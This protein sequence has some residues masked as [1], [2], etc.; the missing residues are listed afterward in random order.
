MKSWWRQVK[1]SLESSYL[2]SRGTM[3]AALKFGCPPLSDHIVIDPRLRESFRFSTL[4]KAFNPFLVDSEDGSQSAAVASSGT[5]FQAQ[6][7][8]S[9]KTKEIYKPLKLPRDEGYVDSEGYRYSLKG[10][11]H[12]FQ[13]T[14]VG[15]NVVLKIGNPNEVVMSIQWKDEVDDSLLPI[16]HS[17]EDPVRLESKSIAP[18]IGQKTAYIAKVLLP[19]QMEAS[20]KIFAGTAFIDEIGPLC[21]DIQA[22]AEGIAPIRTAYT[23]IETG[24][25]R[26]HGLKDSLQASA[27][28]GDVTDED[29]NVAIGVKLGSV[30]INFPNQFLEE[31]IFIKRQ[32]HTEICNKVGAD[33]QISTRTDNVDVEEPEREHFFRPK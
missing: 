32:K 21:I 27:L 2:D 20:I 9:C 30:K 16:L 31:P 4:R 15:G 17:Y 22:G 26:L 11:I 14:F 8:N 5:F 7:K 1:L 25:M 10:D 23:N 13:A 28:M 12:A 29:S 19:P 33:V 3:R 24:G 6:K 18:F